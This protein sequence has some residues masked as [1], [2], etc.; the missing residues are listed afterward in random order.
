VNRLALLVLVLVAA[1]CGRWRFDELFDADARG[2]DDG[3]LPDTVPCAHTFCD[4]FDRPGPPEADW[5][6]ITNSGLSVPSLTTANVVSSPQAFQMHLPGTSN[7]SGFLVKL[8]PSVTDEVKLE[9]QVAIETTNV[10]DAEIDLIAIH[11]EAPPSPCDD[12]G[13]YLVRDGTM[14][15]NLQETYGN[16]GGNEQNYLPL[17][18][19]TG[20]HK[21]TMIVKPGIAGTA[22]IQ[23]LIDDALAVDH[24]TSHL[25][26]ESTLRLR[27]GAGAARNV[28][29][30]WDF[31]FDD[32]TVDVN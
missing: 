32:L 31:Y 17:L 7:E 6:M 1:G 3:A 2:I 22:T 25:I 10:N 27:L 19:N 8:L 9:V 28:V 5:D 12:F 18:D 13:Y 24:P 4:N 20:F 21:I 30:P 26:P 16:C 11:W 23:L 15:L 29:A 14:Q